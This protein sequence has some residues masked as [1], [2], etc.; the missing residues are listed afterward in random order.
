MSTR[1][2]SNIKFSLK[3]TSTMNNTLTDGNISSISQPNF[4]FI[5]DWINGE[6]HNQV[7]R[8]WQSKSRSL[9]SGASET[10]D[11]F[12]M[13]SEDIG[14]GAGKD[15]LG[16][17]IGF[18]SIAV[19]IIQN[20]NDIDSAGLLEIQPGDTNGWTPIGIH[21]AATG[22]ALY[23]Q[24]ILAKIQ[25]NDNGFPIMDGSL[26]T[27][28]LTANSDDIEYSIYILAREAESTSSSLS[29]SSSS[30]NSSSSSGSSVSS[31]SWSSENSSSI[32]SSSISTSSVSSSSWSV[33]S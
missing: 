27:L 1:T 23:G 6:D 21:T 28:K 31:S 33:Q 9:A 10:L 26:H 32:S 8:A 7:N 3:L 16:Q 22:G 2:L 18:S 30:S 14:A 4:S 19:I 15:A 13:A 17:S 20:D 24:S 29:T 11:L 25:P 5:S 12:D